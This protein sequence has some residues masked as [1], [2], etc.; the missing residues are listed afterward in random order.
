MAKRPFQKITVVRLMTA[1]SEPP[2]SPDDG[3]IQAAHIRYLTSLVDSG[4]ILANGPVKRLDDDRIRGMSLYLVEPE[5][6]RELAKDDPAVKAGW[7][8]VLV[9]EW[10]I[11]ARSRT[12]GDRHDLEIDLPV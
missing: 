5:E 2:D 3:A 12:I 11:P 1:E 6:A 4:T 10:L 8:E 7:F 9:D